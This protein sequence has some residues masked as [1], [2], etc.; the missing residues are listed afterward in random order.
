MD[1]AQ[2]ASAL[3]I[4]AIVKRR[5]RRR[6]EKKRFRSVWVKPWLLNRDEKSAYNNILGELRLKDQ[7]EFRKYLRMNTQ[8]YEVSFIHILSI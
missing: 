1:R 3:A 7:E 5:R 2:T 6:N 4:L 8:T